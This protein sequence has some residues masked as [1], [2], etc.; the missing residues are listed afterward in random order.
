ME[1]ESNLEMGIKSNFERVKEGI[2]DARLVAVTKSVGIEEVKKLIGLGVR[3]LGENRVNVAELK[4][5]EIKSDVC[6]HMI[7]HLQSNKVK[8]AVSLFD[9][10]QSVDSLK[11][12]KLIDKEAGKIGKVMDVLIQ[13]NIAEESQKY[14]IRLLDLGQFFDEASRLG[15]ENVNIKGLMAMAPFVRAEEARSC[16]RE[17]KKLFD[18]FKDRFC[19]SIL[20]MGMTNDYRVAVEEGS[21]MVRVGTALFR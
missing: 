11:L 7:G 18:F 1:I 8:K 9:M 3:D 10:I 15:L 16:F 4:I 13:V 5:N 20:S 17:M 19:L 6:W 12:L 14:G 2:G 21:T